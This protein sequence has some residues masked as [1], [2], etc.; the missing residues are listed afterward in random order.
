[1]CSLQEVT[2][3]LGSGL[4]KE[5]KERRKHKIAFAESSEHDGKSNPDGSNAAAS[6]LS[7]SEMQKIAEDMK[8]KL[9]R[10]NSDYPDEKLKEKEIERYKK[11]IKRYEEL[12]DREKILWYKK[13]R[14]KEEFV[15]T[16]MLVMG[17][18]SEREKAAEH[19]RKELEDHESGIN[20]MDEQYYVFK[21]NALA[22][23]D[24]VNHPEMMNKYRQELKNKFEQAELA[25][26]KKE[27]Q[28]DA[29]DDIAK[30]PVG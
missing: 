18:K 20:V 16:K 7:L 17:N 25:F 5:F 21:K 4:A 23:Y 26:D 29:D 22:R 6:R 2:S 15:E 9:K 3:R 8:A 13:N 1:M 12:M 19:I 24:N 27:I 28:Q 11:F 14:H 10:D 30:G